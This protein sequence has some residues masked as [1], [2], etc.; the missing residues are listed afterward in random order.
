MDETFSLC[1]G[2]GGDH[3]A[4]TTRLSGQSRGWARIRVASPQ[5]AKH[6][7]C[8]LS[9]RRRLCLV[10][11][12]LCGGHCNLAGENPPHLS[13]RQQVGAD[14]PGTRG[15]QGR[16][17]FPGGWVGGSPG[18]SPSQTLPACR[19]PPMDQVVSGT[20]LSFPHQCRR[21]ADTVV[22]GPGPWPSTCSGPAAMSAQPRA[23][24]SDQT[25]VKDSSRDPSR[26]SQRARAWRS[27]P[28]ERHPTVT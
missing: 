8:A 23:A 9:R 7:L 15:L 6:G 24:S 17:S 2:G 28:V 4:L 16:F 19:E 10:A 25:N 5:R 12:V 27:A 18:Q 11:Q 3:T 1:T 21:E 22:A 20:L 13:A 26:A 14:L